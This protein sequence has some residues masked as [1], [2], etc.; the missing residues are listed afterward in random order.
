MRC[1]RLMLHLFLLF[2]F[3]FGKLT[4]SFFAL[5]KSLYLR[6]QDTGHGLLLFDPPSAVRQPH[7]GFWPWVQIPPLGSEHLLFDSAGRRPGLLGRRLFG[8]GSGV[9]IIPKGGTDA[10]AGIVAVDE[11]DRA[12]RRDEGHIVGIVG[13]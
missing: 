12:D 1:S 9:Q 6:E 4:L 11:V 5:E 10:A 7:S 8:R 13:G 3:P 2:C